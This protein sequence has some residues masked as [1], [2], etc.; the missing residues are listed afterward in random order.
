M[1]CKLGTALHIGDKALLLL[2]LLHTHVIE[3]QYDH[4]FTYNNLIYNRS[5][6]KI[7]Q[8]YI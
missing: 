8:T 5:N 7:T 6:V 3:Y 1:N 2:L 4:L